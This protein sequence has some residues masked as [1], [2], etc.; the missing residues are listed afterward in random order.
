MWYPHFLA[1]SQLHG[2]LPQLNHNV[3]ALVTSLLPIAH[4]IVIAQ[5]LLATM[6]VPKCLGQNTNGFLSD[7]NSQGIHKHGNILH[8]ARPVQ[9]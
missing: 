4:V 3:P 8:R 7:L 1:S 2:A 9:N 6:D 5:V